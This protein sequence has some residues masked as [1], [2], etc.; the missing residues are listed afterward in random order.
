MGLAGAHGAMT[1]I[2]KAQNRLDSARGRVDPA[3]AG[4]DTRRDAGLG[5]LP[6]FTRSTS[7]VCLVAGCA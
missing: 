4:Q 6:S 5:R 2:M 1:G 7:F 3:D